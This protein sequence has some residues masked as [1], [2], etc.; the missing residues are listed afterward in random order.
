MATLYECTCGATQMK[1]EDVVVVVFLQTQEE[2]AETDLRCPECGSTTKVEKMFAFLCHLCEDVQVGDEG[3]YCAECA[4][5]VIIAQ[6][7]VM[8]GG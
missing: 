8:R 2:P 4:V 7:N 1:E 6:R 3:D 5:E